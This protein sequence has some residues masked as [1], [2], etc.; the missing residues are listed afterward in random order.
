MKF[1]ILVVL[2]LVLVSGISYA[3]QPNVLD[4]VFVKEHTQTREPLSYPYLRE[5]D[6]MW[7]KRI[8]RVI[9]LNEKINLPLRYP[10]SKINDRQSLIDLL[11]DKIKEGSL[12]A[13][14]ASIT[15]EF[16]A[17]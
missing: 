2:A 1:K 4:G 13:Y 8:W 7:S 17:P 16:V 6:V 12:T 10:L 11:L 5:A 15:D 14:D 9:D 3:Q